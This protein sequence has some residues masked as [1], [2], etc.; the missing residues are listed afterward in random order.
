MRTKYNGYDIE[1]TPTEFK[2][3]VKA[4]TI[5]IKPVQ[6]W[7]TLTARHVPEVKRRSDFGVKRGRH[8]KRKTMHLSFKTRQARADRMIKRN[9]LAKKYAEKNGVSY[10]EAIKILEGF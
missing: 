6:E 3:L 10:R 9:K 7:H 8:K 4:E 5:K 1:L 2:E